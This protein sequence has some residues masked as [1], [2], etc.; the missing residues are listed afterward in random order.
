MAQ[1]HLRPELVTA[2]GEAAGIMMDDQYVGS[3]T[4]LYREQDMLYGSVQLDEEFVNQR[5]KAQIDRFIHRYVQHMI[6]ALGVPE[7][8]VTVTYSDYDHVIS[9]DDVVEVELDE[10]VEDEDMEDV[11]LHFELVRDELD[12]LIYDIYEESGRRNSRLG[13]ATI[14]VSTEEMTAFVEFLNPRDEELREQI[15]YHL[16][17]ML[18]EAFDFQTLTVTMQYDEEVIDEYHFDIDDQADTEYSPAIYAES[19]RKDTLHS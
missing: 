6:D 16:I 2:T 4:L 9:T 11:Y 7:C 13:S 10:T 1:I 12:V 3:M 14:D 15:A 8:L 17:D 5:E 18:E 19:E